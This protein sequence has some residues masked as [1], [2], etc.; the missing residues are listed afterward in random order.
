MA[1]FAAPSTLPA[2]ERVEVCAKYVR[3]GA[4]YHVTATVLSGMELNSATAP[5]RYKAFSTYVVIFW[6]EGEATVIEL[7]SP[8][9]DAF[10]Q[11]GFDQYDRGWEVG[12]Y[13]GLCY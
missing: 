3:S 9:L 6:K 10:S 1:L 2:R 12:R 11:S 4:A 13:N 8:W 7:Q 5:F